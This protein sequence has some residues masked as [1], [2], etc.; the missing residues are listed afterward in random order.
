[1]DT[2]ILQQYKEIA[3]VACMKWHVH[4]VL[5]TYRSHV[6]DISEQITTLFTGSWMTFFGLVRIERGTSSSGDSILFLFIRP[7]KNEHDLYMT[8]CSRQIGSPNPFEI[9]CNR[10]VSRLYGTF[11]WDPVIE[12][13]LNFK[14]QGTKKSN[15][16]PKGPTTFKFWEMKLLLL[17]LTYM[18]KF[19][20]LLCWI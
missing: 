16:S 9:N 10:S 19:S 18:Q 6:P 8:W 11:D 2:V 5:I 3:L 17:L 15:F 12:I 13:A 1:M 4:D 20:S 14:S 7:M